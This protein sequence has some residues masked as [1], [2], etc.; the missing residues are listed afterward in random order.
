MHRHALLQRGE[1]IDSSIAEQA[2]IAGRERI[3]TSRLTSSLTMHRSDGT[4]AKNKDAGVIDDPAVKLIVNPRNF[5][6]NARPI[7]HLLNRIAGPAPFYLASDLQ[8]PPEIIPSSS[9]N[10]KWATSWW[11]VYQAGQHGKT[12]WWHCCA[13]LLHLLQVFSRHLGY[14]FV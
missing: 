12:R 5:G 6:H 9:V 13:E 14:Y 3:T 8:D 11:M 1:N 4:V 2:A 7:R 10:G